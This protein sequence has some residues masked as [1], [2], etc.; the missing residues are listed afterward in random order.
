M[1]CAVKPFWPPSN[2]EKKEIIEDNS[3][4]FVFEVLWQ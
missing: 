3:S 1:I 4:K 2:V